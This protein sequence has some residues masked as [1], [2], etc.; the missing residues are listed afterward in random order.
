MKEIDTSNIRRW[1]KEFRELD[2]PHPN[3]LNIDTTRSSPA[4]TAKTILDHIEERRRH[5]GGVKKI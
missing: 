3:R 2:V 5:A 1:T 4:R